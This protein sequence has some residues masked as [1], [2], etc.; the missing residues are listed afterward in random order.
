[1][2]RFLKEFFSFS[3]SELRIIVILSGLIFI[4]LFIRVFIPVREFQGFHLTADEQAAVDSFIQSLEKISFEK[5]EIGF[6]KEMEEVIPNYK[7]FDPNQVSS[8]ELEEM[9]F[10]EFLGRNLVRYRNSGGKFRTKEDVKKLYGFSDSIYNLWENYIVVPVYEKIDTFRRVTYSKAM[11]EV[12]SADSAQ[13][14]QI[15]GIGP[16]FAGKIIAYRNSLGGFLNLEQLLE[17]RGMNQEKLESI[18]EQVLVDTLFLVK[19]NINIATLKELKN[20]PYI[21][22]RLAESL[23]KYREFAK[24]IK[25]W[26]ELLKN[27]IITPVEFEKLHPYISV[28]EG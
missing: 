26:D 27:R 7:E 15:N 16:Y 11:V 19:I 25:S 12:N 6:Q 9:G 5:K 17:V 3:R 8:E 18:R 4:S 24:S 14:L 2:R 13:L 28:G 23:I 21:S 20:H 22:P 10:P 1:M